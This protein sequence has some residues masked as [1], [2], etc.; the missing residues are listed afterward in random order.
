MG[1]RWPC[2]KHEENPTH[3]TQT[4]HRI[5]DA[6]HLIVTCCT[7]K[8]L[9]SLPLV[10]GVRLQNTENRSTT[11]FNVSGRNKIFK[12]AI[13]PNFDH[14]SLH[15]QRQGKMGAALSC[16]HTTCC[17]NPLL[18]AR[19]VGRR[20]LSPEHPLAVFNIRNND[21]PKHHKNRS[22][23]SINQLNSGIGPQDFGSDE[24]KHAM[25]K[26]KYYA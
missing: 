26:G 21:H 11:D 14:A 8:V 1:S 20:H 25:P 17:T 24:T 10:Q 4:P 6:Q 3:Q 13:N 19:S 18:Q 16:P 22:E 9:S 23:A 7:P 2:S 12:E 15:V 5:E